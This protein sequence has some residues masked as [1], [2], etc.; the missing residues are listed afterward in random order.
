[1][2][3]NL[4][5]EGVEN[6]EQYNFLCKHGVQVIQGY[7]LSAPVSADELIPMLAPWHFLNSL[8]GLAD[9]IKVGA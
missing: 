9:G 5:A 4:V 1:M 7:L 3:L 2:Q 6:K 8:R